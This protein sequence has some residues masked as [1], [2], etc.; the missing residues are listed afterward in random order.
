MVIFITV[1]HYRGWICLQIN[2]NPGKT[3]T[4]ILMNDDAITTEPQSQEASSCFL[5]L[6]KW[7]VSK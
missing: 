7:A 3:P 5:N 4:T 6:I 1:T 2:L